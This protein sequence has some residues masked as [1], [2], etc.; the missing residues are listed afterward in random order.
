MQIF[1]LLLISQSA[2]SKYDVL[3]VNHTTCS[4]TI[5]FMIMLFDLKN[6]ITNYAQST[7]KNKRKS[8]YINI[9][10][11]LCTITYLKTMQLITHM[12]FSYFIERRTA[13]DIITFIVV[14]LTTF[15]TIYQLFTSEQL[16]IKYIYFAHRLLLHQCSCVV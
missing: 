4:F 1:N 12:Y 5:P 7:H 11:T 9:T 10:M 14:S 2:L 15:K 13:I 6:C 3:N 16:H 8:I